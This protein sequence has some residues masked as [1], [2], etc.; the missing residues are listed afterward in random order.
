MKAMSDRK[1]KNSA[2][3]DES[4]GAFVNLSRSQR[5]RSSGAHAGGRLSNDRSRGVE[6]CRPLIR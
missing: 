6:R 2:S 3:S 5:L 1:S 4:F